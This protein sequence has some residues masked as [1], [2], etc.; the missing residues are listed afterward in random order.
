M[1]EGPQR[2]LKDQALRSPQGF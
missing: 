2:A 1:A